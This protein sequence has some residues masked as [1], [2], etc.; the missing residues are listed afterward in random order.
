MKNKWLSGGM[1]LGFVVCCAMLVAAVPG[2]FSTVNATV[3]Y[4]VN[5]A[6]GTSG[7]TLCSDGT[8]YSTPCSFPTPP[9]IY[10]QNLT[11]T[12]GDSPQRGKLGFS[13][14][15]HLQDLSGF[16][17]TEVDLTPSGVTAGTYTCATVTVDNFG[18]V[19]SLS[20]GSCGTA[21]QTIV[22][23]STCSTGGNSYQGCSFT[24]TW[25]VAF[26]DTAYAATCTAYGGSHTANGGSSLKVDISS[27]FTTGLTILL[28]NGTADGAINITPS[29]VDCIGVHP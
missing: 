26:V 3:G 12:A 18:R 19:T 27:K 16:N 23:T 7:Q 29:E 10:Y 25:P 2:L 28:T 15:F 4:Q 17:E 24:A 9:T 14:N 8:R 21:T 20:N 13:A 11:S 6:A 5:G 22:A 1:G